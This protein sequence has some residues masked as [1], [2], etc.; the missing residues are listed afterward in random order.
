MHSNDNKNETKEETTTTTLFR[1]CIYSNENHTRTYPMF[2][3]FLRI[4]FFHFIELTIY[5]TIFTL[6]LSSL[7]CHHN[8]QI[9]FNTSKHYFR[10]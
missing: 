6:F 3:L 4:F 2:S 7:S 9:H 5:L 8:T 10:M 1:M